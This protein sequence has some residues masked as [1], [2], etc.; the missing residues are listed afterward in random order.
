MAVV[1]F[2]CPKIASQ[3]VVLINSKCIHSFNK[4]FSFVK[5]LEQKIGQ[6][7]KIL[8]MCLDYVLRQRI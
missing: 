5:N 3:I 1:H 8:V 7:V 4:T 6:E 2:P